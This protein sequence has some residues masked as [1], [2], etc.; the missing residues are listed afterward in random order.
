M[1]LSSLI[2]ALSDKTVVD[3]F[4]R[5]IIPEIIPALQATIESCI[6]AK[7]SELREENKKLKTELDDHLLLISELRNEN[8]ELKTTIDSHEL[9]INSTEAYLRVDNLIFKGLPEDD[10]Y[11]TAEVTTVKVIQ[12]ANDVLKIPISSSDI[13]IAHR[14]PKGHSDRVKPVIAR[15]ANRVAREKVYNARATLK[16]YKPPSGPVFI[17][18]HL[19]KHN[20][21][22]FAACRK[23]WKANKVA[24]AWTWSC[25]TYVKC[26]SSHGGRT[27]K[28]Q[29]QADIDNLDIPH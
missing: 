8:Q 6:D 21:E 25:C 20:D 7:L 15:F 23:L 29:S 19:T 14:L 26:L 1:D 28:I 18:E 16:S 2:Q 24:G 27:V 4:A 22:L 12:F 17:N 13:S 3:S 11:E 10:G 9:R 5:A